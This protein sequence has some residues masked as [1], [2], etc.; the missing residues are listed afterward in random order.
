M[1]NH[2]TIQTFIEML[3]KDVDKTFSQKKKLKY[4]K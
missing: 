2:H 1:E 3:N 4:N